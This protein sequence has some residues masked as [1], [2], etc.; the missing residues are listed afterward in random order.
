MEAFHVC[1]PEYLLSCLFS[2]NSW[3][4]IEHPHTPELLLKCQSFRQGAPGL[5]RLFS[6]HRHNH[7]RNSPLRHRGQNVFKITLW[8]AAETSFCGA[9][10]HRNTHIFK[11]NTHKKSALHLVRHTWKIWKLECLKLSD[12]RWIFEVIFSFSDAGHFTFSNVMSIDWLT[13]KFGQ[14]VGHNQ[15]FEGVN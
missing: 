12:N 2:W 11:L 1:L 13:L 10:A 4:S 9:D 7:H 5:R 14:L 15:T 6:F 3:A 8:R